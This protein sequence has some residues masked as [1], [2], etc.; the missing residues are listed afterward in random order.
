M[1]WKERW[2]DRTSVEMLLPRYL[3]SCIPSLK[4][5]NGKSIGKCQVVK[6][7]VMIVGYNVILILMIWVIALTPGKEFKGS[8]RRLYEQNMMMISVSYLTCHHHIHKFFLHPQL[9]MILE[10]ILEVSLKTSLFLLIFNGLIQ[11]MI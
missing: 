5:P 1:E 6:V 2:M 11:H 10:R 8:L 4:K 3:H 7:P 9:K